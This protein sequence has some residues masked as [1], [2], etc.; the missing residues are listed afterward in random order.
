MESN[1]LWLCILEIMFIVKAASVKDKRQSPKCGLIM[2]SRSVFL[3]VQIGS[4]VNTFSPLSFLSHSFPIFFRLFPFSRSMSQS[5]SLPLSLSLSLCLSLSHSLLLSLS[6]SLSLS[7]Y[8]SSSL[9]YL[10]SF[11]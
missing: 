2:K 7:L 6:L 5:L 9:L 1:I 10:H 3:A 11:L 4:D 8:M